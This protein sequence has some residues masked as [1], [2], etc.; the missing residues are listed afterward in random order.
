MNEGFVISILILGVV[1]G[2]VIGGC[3]FDKYGRK[4]IIRMLVIIFFFVIIICLIVFDVNIMIV[5][6]FVLGLVVGGVLVIVL[7]FLVELV[8]M[9]LRGS[10]VFKNELMIV[11]G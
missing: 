6:R 9:Y 7:I 5:F 11:I 8:F 1:F 3:L 10:I 4:K 2:V